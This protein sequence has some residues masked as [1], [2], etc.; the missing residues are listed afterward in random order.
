M[1]YWPL[2]DSSCPYIQNAENQKCLYQ[3]FLTPR[4]I[5][6]FCERTSVCF[7]RH[8]LL[9]GIVQLFVT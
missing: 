8:K 6:R 7:T 2:A 4:N 9:Y 3:Q 1:H 5:L